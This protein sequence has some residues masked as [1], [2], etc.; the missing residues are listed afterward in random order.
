MGRGATASR[1]FAK[2][3]GYPISLAK[4]PV[5][6]SC[7]E[8][9]SAL[10]ADLGSIFR[11][12]VSAIGNQV[13]VLGFRYGFG[14]AYNHPSPTTGPGFPFEFSILSLG[15]GATASRPFAKGFG[16]PISLAKS[17]V[18]F[19]CF[20][21]GSALRADLE[22]IFRSRVSALRS[23][24]RVIRYRCGCRS[25]SKSA[26]VQ[27]AFGLCKGAKGRGI[28]ITAQYRCKSANRPAACAKVQKLRQGSSPP[29]SAR[30]LGSGG[31]EM[32]HQG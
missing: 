27:P 11:S 22:S 23:L 32:R 7:L 2:G 17:P 19:S 1:P 3:F 16:Y 24:V 9:G 20:E 6:F 13:R 14:L 15:R 12:Q 25:E 30:Y 4:S 5:T 29:F 10:R 18:T 8:V 28:G 21:V 31:L 26:K